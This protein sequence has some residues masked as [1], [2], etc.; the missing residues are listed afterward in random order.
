MKLKEMPSVIPSEVMTSLYGLPSIFFVRSRHLFYVI[1]IHFGF[2][3]SIVEVVR[4]K[5]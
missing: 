1:F 3:A 2:L 4:F 5:N